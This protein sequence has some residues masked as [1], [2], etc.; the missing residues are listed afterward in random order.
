MQWGNVNLITPRKSEYNPLSSLTL[1]SLL[2][3]T[4]GE[5]Y[6]TRSK[7]PDFLPNGTVYEAMK[8]SRNS[9]HTD[10][11]WPLRV[12]W[13]GSFQ[14]SSNHKRDYPPHAIFADIE[15]EI[16]SKYRKKM[17][18]SFPD[19]G[20]L[21]DKIS[22]LLQD[23]Y[24]FPDGIKT[25]TYGKE[26]GSMLESVLLVEQLSASH[27]E[28]A[29]QIQAMIKFCGKKSVMLAHPSGDKD[30]AVVREGFKDFI[31]VSLWK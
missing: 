9:D 20:A 23:D 31:D 27:A 29:R 3:L 14:T 4:K 1:A 16:V 17:I 12:R 26:T 15:V 13:S 6:L 18:E 2:T 11:P 24:S 10:L 5:A 28:Y 25:P 19:I 22:K 8:C 30:S 21:R 7:N